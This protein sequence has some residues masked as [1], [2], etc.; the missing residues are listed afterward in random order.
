MS[1]RLERVAEQIRG[2][3]ARVLREET[4]DPRIRMVTVT[5]VDV[6]PDLRR[7]LV[8][9]SRIEAKDAPELEAVSQGLASASRFIR[10]RLARELPLK[11]M[12]ELHFRYDASLVDGDAML[13][14]MRTMNDER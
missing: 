3:I 2:E 5:R 11:R 4:T 9:W 13:A 7:A 12:P 1:R 14:L 8:L 10:G 6:A